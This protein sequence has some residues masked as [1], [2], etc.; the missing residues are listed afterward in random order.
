MKKAGIVFISLGAAALFTAVAISGTVALMQTN[1]TINNHLVSGDY[2]ATLYLTS[3]VQDEFTA[4]GAIAPSTVDLST[5]QGYEA[6]KGVNLSVYGEDIF[7]I[8]RIVPT[9]SGTATFSLTNT[10]NVPFVYNANVINTVGY[11][12]N[13]A[14]HSYDASDDVALLS[15]LTITMNDE[16]TEK[17]LTPSQTA[18][19]SVSYLFPDLANNNDAINQKVTFDISVT[20][21]QVVKE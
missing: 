10:G 3:L 17:K 6:G 5:Y 12:Y 13:E 19:F 14:S 11:V 16:N 21:T 18:N 15:Q 20:T 2:K 4:T 1:R 7:N 8:E 9:M